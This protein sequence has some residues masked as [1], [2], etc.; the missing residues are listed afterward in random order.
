MPASRARPECDFAFTKS[1]PTRAAGL[2]ERRRTAVDNRF[3][4]RRFSS[5]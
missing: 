5:S 1:R 2:S 3:G 4:R